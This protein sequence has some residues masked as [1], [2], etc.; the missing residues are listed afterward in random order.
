MAVQGVLSEPLSGTKF[1]ANREKYREA[2]EFYP[3]NL[4]ADLST[5]VNPGRF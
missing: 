5:A 2:F 4:A 1:P 3:Q